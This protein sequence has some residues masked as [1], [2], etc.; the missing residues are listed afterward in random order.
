MINQMTAPPY[1]G[2]AVTWLLTQTTSEYV[3]LF[4]HQQKNRY[5]KISFRELAKCGDLIVEIPVM[6][7][8]LTCI[9]IIIKEDPYLIMILMGHA[10]RPG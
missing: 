9:E 8:R 3:N 7:T 10:G 5:H 6:V 1:W 4:L 2:A